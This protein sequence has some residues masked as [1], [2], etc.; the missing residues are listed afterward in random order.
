MLK[1]VNLIGMYV[2]DPQKS[3]EFYQQLGFEVVQKEGNDPRQAAYVKLGDFRLKF[4]A[5][6][7]AKDE[8]ERYQ[9]EAFGEPKGTGLYINVEVTDIDEFFQSLQSKGT[10]TSSEP[11]DWPWGQREFVTRDPDGYKLVFYQV[12]T[13]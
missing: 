7:T 13:S 6:D 3:V 4:T 12:I 11:R 5:K 2:A 10:K 9:K 8:S 1:A